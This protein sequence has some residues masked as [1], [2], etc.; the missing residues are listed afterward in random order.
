MMNLTN[1]A[2]EA[3]CD[4]FIKGIIKKTLWFTLAAALL[5]LLLGQTAHAKGLALGGLAS[6][7]N[8]LFMALWLPRV[9]GRKLG[10]KVKT[11]GQG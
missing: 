1:I 7:A 5:L 8:F 3:S 2:D 4:A 10:R 11:K 9:L 6:A